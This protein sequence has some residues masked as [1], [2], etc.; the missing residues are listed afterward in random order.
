MKITFKIIKK[1]KHYSAV[2]RYKNDNNILDKKI[3]K[4]EK[5]SKWL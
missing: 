1:K 3:D 2:D 4:L 5:G